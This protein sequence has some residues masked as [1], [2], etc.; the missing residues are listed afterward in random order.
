MSN[1]HPSLDPCECGCMYVL[2]MDMHFG[3]RAECPKCGIVEWGK[4]E[5]LCTTNWNKRMKKETD[6]EGMVC[7]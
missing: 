5:S 3:Y 4:N 1:D 7:K 2:M 6:D